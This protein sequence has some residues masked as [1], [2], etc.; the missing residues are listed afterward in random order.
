M[1]TSNVNIVLVDVPGGV[2]V[3]PGSNKC[4]SRRRCFLRLFVNANYA[5][6]CAVA[7]YRLTG[8]HGNTITA[9]PV[10]RPRS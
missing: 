8:D 9:T 5:D 6:T 4:V 1:V 2:P 3:L 7:V 10:F